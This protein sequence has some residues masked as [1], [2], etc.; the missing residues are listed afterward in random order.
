M[1]N[2]LINLLSRQS[3]PGLFRFCINLVQ[4][5]WSNAFCQSMKQIHSSS[6]ISKVRSAI[7]LIIKLVINKNYT[8]MRIQR[9]KNNTYWR[10]E[11]LL[12]CVSLLN[13]AAIVTK[14]SMSVGH[15]LNDIV[16]GE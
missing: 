7:I 9:N 4:F 1:Y 12:F 3:I 8:E 13:K 16:R 15:L 6:S 5:T 2:F 14:G 10:F 11:E